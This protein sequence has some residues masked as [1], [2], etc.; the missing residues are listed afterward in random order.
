MQEPLIAPARRSKTP[1]VV[2]GLAV[3]TVYVVVVALMWDHYGFSFDTEKEQPA[4][5]IMTVGGLAVSLYVLDWLRDSYKASA[6][7][8]GESE[9]EISEVD[10]KLQRPELDTLALE[11]F[12][13]IVA[14]TV[15]Q[16][17]RKTWE[18]E[19]RDSTAV[20]SDVLFNSFCAN[21]AV[22]LLSQATSRCN[23][24][25][26]VSLDAHYGSHSWQA[27]M[28][29]VLQSARYR[30]FLHLVV[31]AHI[32][33]AFAESADRSDGG[34]SSPFSLWRTLVESALLLVEILDVSLRLF[35]A[36]AARNCTENVLSPSFRRKQRILHA[37]IV[38]WMVFDLILQLTMEISLEYVVPVRPILLVLINDR[39]VESLI[40]F[41]ASVVA[42]ADLFGMYALFIVVCAILGTLHF[43]SVWSPDDDNDDVVS[44]KNRFANVVESF[45]SMFTYITTNENYSDVTYPGVEAYPT[46]IVFVVFMT[47]LG[48]MLLV[49][50]VTGVFENAFAEQQTAMLRRWRLF[51]RAGIVA[52]HCLVDLDDSHEVSRQ[53]FEGFV[54]ALRPELRDSLQYDELDS[55]RNEQLDVVEFVSG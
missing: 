7:R 15:R 3:L 31:M 54:T 17:A 37:A 28:Y 30:V 20:Q 42:A 18:H 1:L 50:M 4:T 6:Y 44:V 25:S 34:L 47:I 35:F 12:R 10:K 52:A 49:A 40:G 24:L 43:H 16:A 41:C 38:G 39:A 21:Y 9:S 29:R 45:M 48:S 19:Q 22:Q 26:L 51:E 46:S 32:L 13:G 11:D 27:R 55:D 14:P 23:V 33:L 2:A 53:E 5:L 8:E 36:F